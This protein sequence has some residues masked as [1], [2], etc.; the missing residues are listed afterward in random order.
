MLVRVCLPTMHSYRRCGLMK[1]PPI[2]LATRGRLTCPRLPAILLATTP[3]LSA[4]DNMPSRELA[5]LISNSA[6]LAVPRSM[7]LSVLFVL[8]SVN[9]V[10]LHGHLTVGE[11]APP[12][13]GQSIPQ[14]RWNISVRLPDRLIVISGRFGRLLLTDAMAALVGTGRLMCPS[15][16]LSLTLKNSVRFPLETCTVIRPRLLRET[17]SGPLVLRT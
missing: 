4:S 9:G 14:A 16:V 8:P 13:L 11:T 17:T 3:L 6:A 1:T 5:E 15:L 7:R 2:G 10:L 12:L